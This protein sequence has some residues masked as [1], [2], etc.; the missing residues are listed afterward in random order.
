MELPS[1]RV[2]AQE[3]KMFDSADYVMNN[4]RK[5]PPG[6]SGASTTLSS[7]DEAVKQLSIQ[8]DEPD[9]PQK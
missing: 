5:P 7:T 6:H 8:K 9:V 2:A 4:V 1:T 3:K